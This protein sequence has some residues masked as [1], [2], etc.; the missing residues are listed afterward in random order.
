MPDLFTGFIRI[1][2]AS[3]KRV[4]SIV[5]NRAGSRAYRRRPLFCS[6]LFVNCPVIGHFH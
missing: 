3:E 1:K 5:N 6:S 2:A 4:P